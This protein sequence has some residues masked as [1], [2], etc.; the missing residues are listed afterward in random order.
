MA[1][2]AGGPKSFE[3]YPQDWTFAAGHKIGFLIAPAD[4]D[5][6]LAPNQAGNL[7]INNAGVQLPT[8]RYLRDSFLPSYP[9]TDERA[10]PAPFDVAAR[11]AGAE[12]S[13]DL[14]AKLVTPPAVTLPGTPAKQ[15]LTVSLRARGRTLIASGKAATGMKLVVR[16]VKGRRTVK[17]ARVTAKAGAWKA[18]FRRVGKGRFRA[19]VS[20]NSA[21]T[22]IR[23]QSALRRVR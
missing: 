8:L 5:W 10:R 20:A 19:L 6:Y 21:G 17:T 13:F 18:T 12:V 7:S 2:T 1:V 4:E 14:P 11:I 9:T 3:L 22:R 16:L 15:R 23:V